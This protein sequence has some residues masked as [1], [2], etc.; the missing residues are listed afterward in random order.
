VHVVR[1]RIPAMSGRIFWEKLTSL[2]VLFCSRGKL[3]APSSLVKYIKD[4]KHSIY[5]E[6]DVPGRSMGSIHALCIQLVPAGI[7]QL[8]ISDTNR[9]NLGKTD[10][11]YDSVV[12][13]LGKT[14]D[15]VK[16]MIDQ[17]WEAINTITT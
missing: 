13:R 9:K 4:N 17:F 12:I 6:S 2:L 16:I 8:S 3:E 10:L 7:L 1:K 11:G 14:G 5:H 15:E